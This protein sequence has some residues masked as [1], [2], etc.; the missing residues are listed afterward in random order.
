MLIGTIL[1]IIAFIAM[2]ILTPFG[3]YLLSSM[4]YSYYLSYGNVYL[5]EWDRNNKEPLIIEY[6]VVLTH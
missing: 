4:Y 5:R 1:I 6:E 3:M 2:M